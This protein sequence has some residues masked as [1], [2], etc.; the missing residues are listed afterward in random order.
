MPGKGASRDSVTQQSYQGLRANVLL[1]VTRGHDCELFP[2]L[3][4]VPQLTDYLRCNATEG[5]RR[6]EI[7]H[8]I[9]PE[10][11]LRRRRRYQIQ[12]EMRPSFL[13]HN[14]ARKGKARSRWE[15]YLLNGVSARSVD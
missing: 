10:R 15:R 1:P 5:V 14:S 12:I 7:G 13:S 3:N 11:C 4:G 6:A 9:L 2:S 8:Q